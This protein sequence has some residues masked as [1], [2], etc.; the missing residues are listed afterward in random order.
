[1]ILMLEHEAST[2]RDW[3]DDC[4][5]EWPEWDFIMDCGTHSVD[6]HELEKREDVFAMQTKCKPCLHNNKLIVNV[7]LYCMELY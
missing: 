5:I 4:K 2:N 3:L 1:M 6:V 7:Y